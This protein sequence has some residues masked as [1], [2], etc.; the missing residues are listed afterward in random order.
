MELK[1]AVYIKSGTLE[2]VYTSNVEITDAELE[3]VTI[4][5]GVPGEKAE[6]L[7]GGA[8]EKLTESEYKEKF[9]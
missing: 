9:E 2:T 7:S 6:A 8:W 5:A 4:Q 1:Y 3:N